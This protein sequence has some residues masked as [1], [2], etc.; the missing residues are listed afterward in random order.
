MVRYTLEQRVF[1]YD[2]N[3]KYGSACKCRQK[4]RRKFRGERVPSRQTIHNLVNKLRT[5]GFLIDKK[6]KHKRRVLTEEKL[7]EVGARLFLP[8]IFEEQSLQQ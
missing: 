8:G 5:T 6:T 1:V 2:T 4:F 7:D 3:V